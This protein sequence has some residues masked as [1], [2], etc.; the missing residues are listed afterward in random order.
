MSDL[1]IAKACQAIQIPGMI[2]SKW[3]VIL[4]HVFLV[5]NERA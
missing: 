4:N 5:T 3:E 2:I 1:D